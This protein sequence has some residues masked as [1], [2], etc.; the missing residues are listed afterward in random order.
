VLC[1]P[2]WRSRTA[3]YRCVVDRK[4][5]RES[6]ELVRGRRGPWCGGLLHRP[7]RGR[8]RVVEDGRLRGIVHRAAGSR[9]T[10]FVRWCRVTI[11]VTARGGS[12]EPPLAGLRRDVLRSEVGVA[13]HAPADR[14]VAREAWPRTTRRS[15]Q[16]SATSSVSQRSVAVAR[17]DSNA[18][19]RA[20][21]SL[22]VPASH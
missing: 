22:P 5:G 12:I 6:G 11:R 21:L 2:V 10:R 7:R 14:D 20:G 13:S 15:R 9:T 4:A 18:C 17:V 19:Q 8:R 16:R 3:L 1:C